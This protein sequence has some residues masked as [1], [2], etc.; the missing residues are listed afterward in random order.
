MPSE[1]SA[2]E[3]QPIPGGFN[4]R[5]RQ[6]VASLEIA[7]RDICTGV[8][9]KF[10][11]GLGLRHRNNRI[12]CSRS[13][14]SANGRQVW[15]LLRIERNHRSKQDCGGQYLW[16]QQQHTRCDVSAVRITTGNEAIAGESVMLSSR[17]DKIRQLVCAVF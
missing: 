16:P 10:I 17:Y 14:P 1:A 8:A 6:L 2:K 5:G 4:I 11:K 12:V 13:D 15:L 3:G 9:Q 7:D